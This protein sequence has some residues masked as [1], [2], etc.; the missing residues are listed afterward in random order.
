[1]KKSMRKAD[2]K[3]AEAKKYV[4]NY[5]PL[6]KPKQVIGPVKVETVI[7]ETKPKGMI[8][9]CAEIKK[10]EKGHFFVILTYGGKRHEIEK[11]FKSTTKAQEWISKHK[12]IDI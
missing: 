10:R 9:E 6:P 12:Y 11:R 4:A 8:V 5:K 2:A 1:M 7:V 3:L